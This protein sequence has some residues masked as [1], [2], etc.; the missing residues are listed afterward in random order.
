[1]DDTRLHIF[2]SCAPGIETLLA[3][4]CQNLNLKQ[5]QETSSPDPARSVDDGGGIL[6]EGGLLD[7]YSANLHLRTASRV[8]VRMG[9]FYAASFAEL[10]KKAAR[11]EWSKFI[12]PGRELNISVTCHKSRLYHSDAV[13]ERVLGAINDS[14]TRRNAGSIVCKA[15][16]NGQ[17]VL[18]RL[19]NDLCTISVDSSGE[20]LHK[21]GY[22][23]ETAKAPLRETLA[24]A[25]LLAFGWDGSAPLIDPFCGSG[26]IPIEAALLASHIPPGIARE[27]AFTRWPGFEQQ[28][29]HELL[30]A[31]RKEIIS[32]QIKIIG[33]DR[34]AGAIKMASANAA[35]AGQ[36][37]VI[38]FQQQ[39]ISDLTPLDTAGWI[40]TNPPYG[41][42][43]STG[44]DLRDLYARFGKILRN[45][46]MG[47]HAGILSN[48]PKLSGNMG[49]PLPYAEWRFINGGIPVKFQLFD[50]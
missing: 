36:K 32:P 44:K 49:L 18:V 45:D 20:L 6:L 23:L 13:A 26:T 35:R 4:E 19:V 3:R 21:R 33:S 11:L 48:D 24:A 12:L 14:F 31:A 34:D 22:R 17:L 8:S 27:F 43:V 16:K 38:Q 25:M 5:T 50:F 46:F 1:M 41:V 9:A 10:R 39:S 28:V 42:R 2:V 40:V 47:W 7:L 37:D 30:T 29:W 15:G